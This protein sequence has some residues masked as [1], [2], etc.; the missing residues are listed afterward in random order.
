MAG[1][2][3]GRMTATRRA[4]IA[5]VGVL[6][7]MVAVASGTAF[8]SSGSPSASTGMAGM[9]AT[10]HNRV[11]NTKGWYAGRTVTFHYTK[12]FFCKTPPASGASTKCEAGADYI[13]IPAHTFDPLYVVVPL[14]FTPPKSTLQCPVAGRCIDHPHTIDLSAVL[15]SGTSN[16]LLPPHSHVVAT[17][18][19]GQ[20][21][22]WNVDV[23][24]VK[25]PKAW[26]KIVAA[27]SD[28]ELRWLQKHDSKEVTGNI[29]TNLF[30]YFAV[31]T[32]NR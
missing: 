25:S 8:A 18:N 16:A 23:V 13:R 32:G 9:S 19:K 7:V 27:K 4:G 2:I 24:G 14:G 6:G 5:L 3:R 21:E 20:A 10:S 30:L 22:W 17:A 12:N 28:T 11:G 1:K 15:G 26:D 29:T 31:K